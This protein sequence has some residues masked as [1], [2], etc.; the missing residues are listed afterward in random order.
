[1]RH[2]IAIS[3]ATALLAGGLLASASPASAAPLQPS[4]TTWD[5]VWTTSD[6][7][8]G[9][10]IRIQEH[11]DVIQLCDTAADGYTPRAD[12]TWGTTSNGSGFS[13]AAWGGNGAC[14]EVSASMG[15]DLPENTEIYVDIFL[16][17]NFAYETYHSYLNDH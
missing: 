17:P 6:P 13:L 8:H 9:G 11:G 1:M 5:H 4:A 2:K 10:T 7:A 14:A 15:Y 16:G 3:A 12:V